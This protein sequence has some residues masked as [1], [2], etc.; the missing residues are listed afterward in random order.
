MFRH[1]S[2][3][4]FSSEPFKRNTKLNTEVIK[5]SI[6]LPVTNNSDVDV[7]PIDATQRSKETL[8]TDYFLLKNTLFWSDITAELE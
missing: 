8:G 2:T 1:F 6:L 5:T 4:C 7:F 3:F